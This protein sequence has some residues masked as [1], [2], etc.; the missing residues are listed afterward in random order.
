MK[1][2]RDLDVEELSTVLG[3]KVGEMEDTF[4]AVEDLDLHMRNG[5]QIKYLL[6]RSL[7]MGRRESSGNIEQPGY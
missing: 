1:D 7:H 3:A 4:D 2:I 5:N 6:A